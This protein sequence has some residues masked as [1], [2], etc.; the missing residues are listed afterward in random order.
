MAASCEMLCHLASNMTGVD[1]A[2]IADRMA[3]LPSTPNL[4]WLWWACLNINTL[5]QAVFFTRK[6]APVH[7]EL[8]RWAKVCGFTFA[9]GAFLRACFPV[10]W[11][12]RP[13]ACLFYT[14]GRVVGGDIFDRLVAQSIEMSIG[15]VVAMTSWNAARVLGLQKIAAVARF[16]IPVSYTHLR[17]HETDS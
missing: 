17:A 11:A 13:H 16:C 2:V 9:W 14:P 6:Y 10:N 7:K 3:P 1:K 8:P 15:T 5:G 4:T 12:T